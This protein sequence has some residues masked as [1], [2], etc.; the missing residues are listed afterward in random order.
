MLLFD[1]RM[2]EPYGPAWAG[3]PPSRCRLDNEA[4]TAASVA[5]RGAGFGRS[6]A[7]GEVRP[8]SADRV[9]LA[10]GKRFLG[11]P[12]PGRRET[13]PLDPGNPRSR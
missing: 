1:G 13:K 5:F 11:E 10:L 8:K 2:L 9:A 6:A 3:R 7:V 4:C 12:L